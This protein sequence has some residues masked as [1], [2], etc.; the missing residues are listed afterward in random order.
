LE[1]TLFQKGFFQEDFFCPATIYLEIYS[2]SHLSKLLL[3][4]KVMPE[5]EGRQKAEDYQNARDLAL[6]Y[7]SYRSRSSKEVFDRL[8]RKGYSDEVAQSVVE[9]LTERR[10]LDDRAFAGEWASFSAYRKL[11]GRILLSQELR[12]KG[13]SADIIEDVIRET[14]SPEGREKELALQL[15]HKRIRRFHKKDRDKLMRS[16]INLLARHGF[17]RSIIRDAI[18]EALGPGDD[19]GLGDEES[20]MDGDDSLVP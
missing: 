12:L 16:L 1:E 2:G 7:L 18:M 5:E 6:D 9:Y 11:S 3:E 8:R 17:S 19:D 4:G 10:Y 13:I 20:L 15:A 14:Y